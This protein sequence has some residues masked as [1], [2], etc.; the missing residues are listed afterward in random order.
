MFN[1]SVYICACSAETG[2]YP[3]LE[4]FKQ[5]KQ[6]KY[7]RH[8]KMIKKDGQRLASAYDSPRVKVIEM[9]SEGVLCIS[10]DNDDTNFWKDNNWK[11]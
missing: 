4:N 6:R 1:Q 11:W 7:K 10:G 3:E 9:K 5:K 2:I 8:S